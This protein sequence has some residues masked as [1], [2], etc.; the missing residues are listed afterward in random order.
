M[1]KV[2]CFGILTT[3]KLGCFFSFLSK[4]LSRSHDPGHRSFNIGFSFYWVVLVSWLG[5]QVWLVNPTDLVF[6]HWLF[7]QFHHLIINIVF[8]WV[9]I[10]FSL[11]FI[12][13]SRPHEPWIMI[14]GLTR[15]HLTYFLCYFLIKIFINFIIQ[16]LVRQ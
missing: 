1:I 15:V 9:I 16:Y 5:L 2:V 10:Y 8:A 4:K 12:I 7:F 14:N 13:L 3:F 11:L 6:F